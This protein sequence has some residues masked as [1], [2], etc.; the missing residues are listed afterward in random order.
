MLILDK[1]YIN[2][3]WKI[4]LPL[5][6]QNL[7]SS[8]VNLADNFMIGSYG[9]TNI[10][11]AA[12]ANQFFFLYNLLIFGAVSGGIVIKAQLWGKKDIERIKEVL[13]TELV[14]CGII[15]AFFSVITMVFPHRIMHFYSADLEV[16][17]L[18]SKYLQF[19]SPGFFFL[20][21]TQVFS[22]THRSIGNVRVPTIITSST[23]IL[24]IFLNL[25][26]IFGNLGFPQMGLAGAGLG[27]T[28]ARFIEC[29]IILLYT[30]LC[31]TPI[32]AK[33]S[34]IFT[35]NREI[36]IITMKKII[37]ITVNEGLYG[38]GLNCYTA[39]Y[40]GISTPAIAAVGA[41]LPIDNLMYTYILGVSSA[42]AVMIG[43]FLGENKKEKAADYAKKTIILSFFIGICIGGLVFIL[44]SRILSFYSLSPISFRYAKRILGY[45]SIFLCTRSINYTIMTGILR[46][47]GD[48]KYCFIS[49]TGSIW[50]VGIP[51]AFFLSVVFHQPITIVYLA[52]LIEHFV[53]L[54]LMVRRYFSGMWQNNFV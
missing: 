47:G 15:G 44:R 34:E 3:I 33:V 38:L 2:N 23:F 39:I 35:I 27:S 7:I 24:K 1:E 31:K 16:V 13:G 51:L 48:V 5:I 4:G 43:N 9:D 20:S 54:F 6:L 41:V 45:L 21:L 11:A 14:W 32:A 17:N 50:L 18:A 26:F 22:G 19:L 52:V 53:K 12:L 46:A 29:L 8:S 25:L 36:A 10:A 28:L 30:Y 37:P 42:S 40:A 49:D